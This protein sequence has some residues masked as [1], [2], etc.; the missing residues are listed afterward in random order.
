MHIGHDRRSPSV[1]LLSCHCRSVFGA[2]TENTGSHPGLEP[3]PAAGSMHSH[4]YTNM[5]RTFIKTLWH[6][7]QYSSLVL[8]QGPWR[9]LQKYMATQREICFEFE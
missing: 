1:T 3:S 2:Y 9:I 4:M 5:G 6:T 7:D 8:T